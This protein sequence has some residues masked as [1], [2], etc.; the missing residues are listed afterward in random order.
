MPT[1][2][3]KN[4]G[5]DKGTS[6]LHLPAPGTVS[7]PTPPPP[8]PDG[9]VSGIRPLGWHPRAAGRIGT[10]FRACLRKLSWLEGSRNSWPKRPSCCLM[11]NLHLEPRDL[12]CGLMRFTYIF[13]SFK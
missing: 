4:T 5:T 11:N 3:Y 12:D 1:S 10:I 8:I 9:D 13:S 2:R 7:I 6:Q